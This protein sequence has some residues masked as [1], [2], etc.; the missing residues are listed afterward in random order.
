MIHFI[1]FFGVLEI[2]IWCLLVYEQGNKFRFGILFY[3][4]KNIIR[5]TEDKILN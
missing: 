5:T 3:D 2:I 4:R 1:I